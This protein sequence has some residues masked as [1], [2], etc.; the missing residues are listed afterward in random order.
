MLARR[1]SPSAVY[2]RAFLAAT[3]AGLGHMDANAVAK[4]TRWLAVIL[5]DE[6]QAAFD[7]VVTEITA[8]KRPSWVL[9]SGEKVIDREVSHLHGNVQ[10][11]LPEVFAGLA[12]G[13]RE[14]IVHGHDFGQAVGRTVCVRTFPNDTI[15][16]AQRLHRKGL[17]RF[18]KNREPDPCS[19]VT[20]VLRWL[21][22]KDCYE[23]VTAYVGVPAEPE[24]WDKEDQVATEQSIAF[25]NSHALVWGSEEI[26][27][28]TETTRCPWK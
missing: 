13:Q 1:K 2:N 16:F 27:P 21:S 26:I 25:W 8:P 15:V 23:I 17:T 19:V 7:A 3:M 9:R 28:G 4:S 5:R 6:G 10:D 24:P 20:V 14:W 22:E 11:F 18:V 12:S